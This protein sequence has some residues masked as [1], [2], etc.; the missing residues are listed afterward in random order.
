[1]SY[2]LFF[3]G[4][5]SPGDPCPLHFG[6]ARPPATPSSF[7]RQNPWPPAPLY[8]KVH[9]VFIEYYKGVTITKET[10]QSNNR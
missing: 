5:R 7:T 10:W 2:N 4:N 1:M 3:K 6:S 9:Y 8:S